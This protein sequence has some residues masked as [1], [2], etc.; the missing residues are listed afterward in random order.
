MIVKRIV[1][2]LQAGNVADAKR[3]YCDVLELEVLMDQGWIMTLGGEHKSAVQIN[4]ATQGGSNT[5]LPA[6]SMEVDDFD[7]VCNRM[8]QNGFEITYGPVDEPW[9]V[10]RFFVI[11]PFG[12]TINILAHLP[13]NSEAK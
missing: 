13:V 10:R 1:T 12:H 7:A 9:G 4:I 11:D 8:K 2:N 5:A 3:F 6:V